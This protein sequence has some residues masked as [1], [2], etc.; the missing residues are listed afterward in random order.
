MPDRVRPVILSGGSGTRLW[1]LSRPLRPKQ[2]LPVADSGT[3]L[4]E[5]LARAQHPMFDHP[6]I[7]AGEE[8]RSL[9]EKQVESIS[10]SAAAI[11]L[12]PQG[13]NTAPAIA[14]AAYCS[15]PAAD[16][17]LLVMPSDHV[18]LDPEEFRDKVAAALPAAEAGAL[19]TFG[20][21]PTRPETGY[22]YIEAGD[23]L[24][25][26]PAVRKVK[27]FVEK[28]DLATAQAFCASGG[29]FWNA[30][31]FLFRASTFLDQLR[32]FAPE[33]DAHCKAAMAEKS[34]D[35]PF[36]RPAAEPFLSCPAISV[37]YA[38]LEKTDRACVVPVDMRWSDVGSWDALWE[39]AAKDGRD[40]MIH[41][42]VVA[43]DADGCLLRGEDG[44][45]VAALGV[46]NLVVVATRDAVLVV[47]R[48]RAQDTKLLVEKLKE[49]GRAKR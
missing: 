33:M 8:H 18:I 45:T 17:I 21:R 48:E 34:V 10:A 28:P 15:D 14:L 41:G 46:E 32:K 38:V 25:G 2:L 20:I 6:I 4:Q 49:L 29:H 23:A 11:I 22:G 16:E 47:P 9:I 36:V 3:M 44:I 43:I 39:I 12:E 5:T 40:N 31:I 7:I 30:G 42:H 35:G 19:V 24:D 13:R 37:D 1:P 26:T 27:R